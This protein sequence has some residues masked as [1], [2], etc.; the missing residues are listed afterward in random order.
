[1]IKK[2]KE[3]MPS[4]KNT[5][6]VKEYAQTLANLKQ[7]IVN[8]QIKSALAVNKE[9]ISLY[10]CVGKIIVEKQADS[11]CGAKLIE[12]LAQDLQNEFPG[13]GGFSRAN[14][15]RMR[16]FF[17]AYT[18]VAQ[19]VRQLEDLPIVSIPCGHNV[20]L[21]QKLKNNNERFWYA[22]KAVCLLLQ[23]L[24]LNCKNKKCSLTYCQTKQNKTNNSVRS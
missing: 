13:I 6:I 10:W 5:A 18:I 22:Q 11:N 7:Q 8:A 16:S 14:I 20:V 15:F 12:Q 4:L 17:L 3:S 9:L 1:M 21:L 2:T 23:K 19:P 24:K